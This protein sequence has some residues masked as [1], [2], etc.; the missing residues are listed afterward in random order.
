[1]STE[2]ELELNYR[3]KA[4][5]Q[6]YENLVHIAKDQISVI[7]HLDRE[8]KKRVSTEH[9]E[10]FALLLSQHEMALERDFEILIAELELNQFYDQLNVHDFATYL[11]NLIQNKLDVYGS[12]MMGVQ[13]LKTL[14]FE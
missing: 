5:K 1:M 9:L 2:E 4:R 10:F 6:T 14:R 7:S 11:Q 13:V 3:L 8:K 12:V